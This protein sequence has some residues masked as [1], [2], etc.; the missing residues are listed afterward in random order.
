MQQMIM[1]LL[2]SRVI[3]I[4]DYHIDGC[5]PI[6]LS[7]SEHFLARVALHSGTSTIWSATMPLQLVTQL[8]ADKFVKFEHRHTI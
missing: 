4:K 7:D 2:L 1:S 6:C 5:R 3:N 8:K